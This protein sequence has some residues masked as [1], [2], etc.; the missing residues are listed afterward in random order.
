LSEN[1]NFSIPVLNTA[2]EGV[3]SEICNANWAQ[4]LE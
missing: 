4:K 1:A 3:S 2:V